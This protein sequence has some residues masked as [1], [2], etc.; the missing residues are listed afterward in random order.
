MQMGGLG[1]S[2]SLQMVLGAS[3]LLGWSTVGASTI[4]KIAVPSTVA[5]SHI[6][7]YTY[8]ISLYAHIYAPHN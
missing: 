5:V 2:Q 4:V 8:H 1:R 3:W 7:R 6:D